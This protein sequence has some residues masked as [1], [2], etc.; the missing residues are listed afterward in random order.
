MEHEGDGDTNCNW[1]TWNNPQRI[2]KGTGRLGNNRTSGDHQDY[3]IIKI[4]QNT[5]K[6]PEDLRRLAVI[7]TSM[8]HDQLKL[9]WKYRK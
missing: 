6:S 7:Q 1:C 4:G 5:E 2:G 9:V 3:S 8:K